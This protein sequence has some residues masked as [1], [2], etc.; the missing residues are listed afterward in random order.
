MDIIRNLLYHKD[1]M[2]IFNKKEPLVLFLGDLVSLLLALWLMLF[3]RYAEI[4]AL[5]KIMQHLVPFSFLFIVWVLI[6]FIAGLYEKQAVLLKN[7]LYA[8]LLRAEVIN[9]VI[10]VLFFYFISYF[11]ITPKTNLFIYLVVSFILVFGWRMYLYPVIGGG[12]KKQKAILI[13][14]GEEMEELKNEINNNFRYGLFFT[15][16]V[17]LNNASS[18]NFKGEILDR[19]HSDD[20]QVIAVDLHNKQIE[21]VLPHLYS[22]L[23]SRVRFID[24]H[25]LYEDVFDKVPVSFLKYN[26][27]LE[28]VS[29]SSGTVYDILKRLMD[30]CVSFILFIISLLL[31]P[32]VYLAIKFDD[33]GVIFSYQKRVG[34]N[35]KAVDIVKFRTMTIANDEASWGAN[36]SL[37]PINKITRLG[38]FL[39]RTRIDELPQL[40]NVLTGDISLIG[41]RPE[42]LEPVKRYT[43]EIPYY[44]VRHIIKPGLSGWAQLY[45]DRHPH[46]GVDTKETKNKLSY[47]LYYIKNR[48]FLLDLTI[49]LKTIKELLS[50][51]GV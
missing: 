35:N 48:S 15:S 38:K 9:C 40:W 16:V 34:K 44:N 18:I 47:D 3:L 45:H 10:A 42:F 6:F 14:S 13:G 1:I 31:Y 11:G 26:W 19:I 2:N 8:T 46:H 29:V 20:V 23:F 50:R 43:E 12:R 17:D 25:Q 28:N 36:L 41:P 37:K 49:A 27:F 33:G 4:P 39:R 21:P 24:M 32:F 51:R 30:I 5:F 22:L 7:K